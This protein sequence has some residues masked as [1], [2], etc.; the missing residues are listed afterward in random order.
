MR[1]DKYLN[2]PIQL[3]SNAHSDIQGTCLNIFY[4]AA[5]AKYQTLEFGSDADKMQSVSKYMGIDFGNW[6]EVLN[7]GRAIFDSLPENLPMTGAKISMI[8]AFRDNFQ[9][10]FH[11]AA[12][13]AFCALKSII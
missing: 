7:N 10:D 4:Y 1:E 2:F 11:I 13:C 3:I 6:Q 5:Y 8:F 12:F 9:T